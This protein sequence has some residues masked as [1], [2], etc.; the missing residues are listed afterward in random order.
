MVQRLL[1]KAVVY[2]FMHK[3]F[4]YG[5]FYL[6]SHLLVDPFGNGLDH[7]TKGSTCENVTCNRLALQTLLKLHGSKSP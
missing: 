5:R 2:I 3:N 6:H 7:F 4:L 1:I